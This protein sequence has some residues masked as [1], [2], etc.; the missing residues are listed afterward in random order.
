[1][2]RKCFLI[3]VAGLWM[4]SSWVLAE[5]TARPNVLVRAVASTEANFPYKVTVNVELE[6]RGQAASPEG[7]VSVLMSPQGARGS[8]PKSD[9]PT[10]W[11]PMNETQPVPALQPGERKT[12]PIDTQY[13]SSSA[14]R[15]RTGSFK[16]RNVD[17]TG[18]DVTVNF[19][20]TLK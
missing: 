5:T 7:T 8:R 3:W 18:V 17:P 9:V 12:I 15:G 14:F 11:D 16:A 4:G 6:N 10:M 20:V 19:S 1:M 2:T 13:F